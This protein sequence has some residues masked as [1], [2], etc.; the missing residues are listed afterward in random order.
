[1]VAEN[2]LIWFGVSFLLLALAYVIYRFEMRA[3][4]RGQQVNSDTAPAP[5]ATATLATPRFDSSTTR[6]QAWKWTR[7]E[8]KHPGVPQPRFL[9]ADGARLNQRSEARCGSWT[10]L[11]TT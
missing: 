6:A 9:R 8:M 3:S 5:A 1:M 11:A 4:K 2:R 7:F 10:K